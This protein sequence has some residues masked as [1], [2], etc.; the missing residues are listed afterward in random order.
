MIQSRESLDELLAA[1][2]YAAI[3]AEAQELI[4]RAL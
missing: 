1:L 3:K 2:P 4:K